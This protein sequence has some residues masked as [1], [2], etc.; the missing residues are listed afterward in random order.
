MMDFLKSY[1]VQAGMSQDMAGYGAIAIAVVA[2]ALL[3]V[4]VNF[5][6]KKLI[7][8]GTKLLVRKSKTTWDDSLLE[9][10]VFDRL[11]Q[12]APALVVYLLASVTFPDDPGIRR[13]IE[14][15][16][17]AYML[18]V[19]A[20]VLSGVLDG[21]LDIYRKYDVSREKP[22]KGY[23]QVLKLLLFL[24]FG[25]LVLSVVL[26][27]SPIIFLSGLGAIMAVLILVFKDTI[28][29][30]VASIQISANDMVRRDDWI[31]MP[32]YG[33]DGDVIDM[34]L[35]TVKVRNWDKTITTIPTYALIS[36][37]FKN[38]RGMDESG[39][40]RIKRAVHIDM[41]SI[42]FCTDEMIERFRKFQHISEYIDGKASELASWNSE[43]DVD[44]SVLVNGRRLT[45]IGTFRAYV[46]AYLRH[47]PLIHQDMTFLVRQLA[48]TENGLPL[49]I[50][51]FSK[52][53]RWAYY[54]GI[55]SDLFDHIL[56][57]IPEFD[58][59]VFQRPSGS[60]LQTL[61]GAT[62]A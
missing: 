59:K 8:R 33:A 2:I 6:A 53:Q 43:H 60:D 25:I 56:A 48:P 30:F 15:F 46:E 31:S 1:F 38:W 17:L 40:R 47:N 52:D 29:G 58:L 23:I 12:I 9:R 19:G 35:T 62:G 26:E 28:L 14:R 36:D 50:Y 22:I 37:S 18:I 16:A 55:Q 7:L 61:A 5:I 39:G 45:N 57:V 11:S 42:R 32:K 24:T 51:V 49:E 4:I 21:I 41:T 3:C 10:H 34:T 13:L 27:K 54:E 44:E 20:R